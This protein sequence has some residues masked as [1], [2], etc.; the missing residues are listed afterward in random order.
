M[1]PTEA[2]GERETGL[3]P[4][5]PQLTPR[6]P[7]GATCPSLLREGEAEALPEQHLRVRSGV[8]IS[9]TAP[10]REATIPTVVT[11]EFPVPEVRQKRITH[12]NP[13]EGE[14]AAPGLTGDRKARARARPRVKEAR[15]RSKDTNSTTA[16][17][18]EGNR[19]LRPPSSNS[20][21]APPGALHLPP[22]P[23]EATRGTTK[24]DTSTTRS[25]APVERGTTEGGEGV[26][27]RTNIP[28]PGI[29]ANFQTPVEVVASFILTPRS[30]ESTLRHKGG[31]KARGRA[32]GGLRPARPTT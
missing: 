21:R 4:I 20:T 16:G 14:A 7:R 22:P 1:G 26:E 28:A 9:T 12:E 29:R 8:S 32:K 13:V 15:Q 11:P 2:Q 25:L 5:N 19:S 6:R 24:G 30:T 18:Q 3:T 17:S 23:L 27:A 10:A 31:T